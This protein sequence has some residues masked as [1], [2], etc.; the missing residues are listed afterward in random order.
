MKPNPKPETGNPECMPAWPVETGGKNMKS[1]K[2]TLIK[3]IA[4]TCLASLAAG[5][6]MF[7][8]TNDRHHNSSV[9]AYLYPNQS[10]HVDSPAIPVLSLPLKVGIAFVPEKQRGSHGD[11]F[12][13]GNDAQFSEEQ[14]MAL[15]KQVSGDF[16]KY[17]F[18]QSIELIPSAYLTP[19]GSFANLDQIRS[20]FGVDIIA[21][22]SYDQVQFTDEGMLSLTYWTVVGAYIIQ[23]EKNDTKTMMDAVVYDLPSRKLLFRAPGISQVKASATPIN[24]SEELR[25]DSELGFKAAATNLVANLQGQLAEFKERVKNSPEEYKIVEKPGY[26]GAASMNVVDLILLAGMGA[27]FLWSRKTKLA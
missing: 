4:A 15:M 13:Y 5:C 20:M 2:S 18:V 17:P 7:Y 21:L 10:D 6:A 3:T 25:N 9:V 16:K 1:R 26:K 8:S 19:G 12:V 27:F 11:A 22:L 14:K 24:L 23:G